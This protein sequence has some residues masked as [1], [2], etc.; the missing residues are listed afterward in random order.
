[1]KFYFNCN[2]RTQATALRECGVKN[3]LLSYQYC[4]EAFDIYA[5]LFD[6]IGVIPGKIENVDKYYAWAFHLPLAKP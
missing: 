3:I 4:K 2:N 6:N 5:K 1:M